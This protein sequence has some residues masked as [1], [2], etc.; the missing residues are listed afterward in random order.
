MWAWNDCVF[1]DQ[2]KTTWQQVIARR[3]DQ[4][5]HPRS[6]IQPVFFSTQL[7]IEHGI[8]MIVFDG[9]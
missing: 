3:Q 6:F 5:H 7:V 2:K 4:S 8:G 9:N 1:T